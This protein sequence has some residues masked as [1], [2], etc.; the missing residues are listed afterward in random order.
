[1]RGFAAVVEHDLLGQPEAE[2]VLEEFAVGLDV[3]R[4]PVPMVE[5]AHIAAARRKALRLVLQRR[6]LVRRRRR[7][8]RCRN[9]VRST[10]P[11]GSLQTKVLPWPRSPSLQPTSK[12]EPFSA[13]ARRSSACGERRAEGD[14]RHAGGLRGGELERIA[15][16]VVPAAQIDAVALLAALGHAHHV[17]EELAALLEFRRQHFEMAEMGD[18]EVRF[19]CMVRSCACR[20]GSILPNARGRRPGPDYWPAS[21]AISAGVKPAS[22]AQRVR[23]RATSR[24]PHSGFS[25]RKLASKAALL[26]AVCAPSR[27]NGP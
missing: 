5:A 22:C 12:P 20:H 8:I 17:D 18:V 16:V 11:S 26:G 7:T 14:M 24:T 9:R 27:M 4:K 25:A 1:M 21:A 13:A 3:D 2:I 15:L 23:D 6:L 10:W 19:G